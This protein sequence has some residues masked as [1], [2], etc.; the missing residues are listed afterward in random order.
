MEVPVCNCTQAAHRGLI[1]FQ[2]EGCKPVKE[3]ELPFQVDHVVYSYQRETSRF[4]GYLC[5]RWYRQ[6]EVV[7][8]L[9][10]GT[11]TALMGRQAVNRGHLDGSRY[12]RGVKLPARRNHIREALRG[13]PNPITIWSVIIEESS[14]QRNAAPNDSC[15]EV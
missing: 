15:V 8:G 13:L 1:G 4:P 5:S 12:K 7:G 14:G 2:D 6:A 11:K 9:I 10:Y 3:A